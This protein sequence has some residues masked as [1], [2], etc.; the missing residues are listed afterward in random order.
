LQKKGGSIA[1][2]KFAGKSKVSVKQLV[3]FD[4]WNPHPYFAA[5]LNIHNLF[6]VYVRKM[7]NMLQNMG[8]LTKA[9]IMDV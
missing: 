8:L 7:L 4:A 9:E 5:M 2:P 1:F 3:R 6:E